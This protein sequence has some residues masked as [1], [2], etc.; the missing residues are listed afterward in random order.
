MRKRYGCLAVAALAGAAFGL[1]WYVWSQPD[2]VHE[3]F[4]AIEHGW[5]QAEVVGVMGEPILV[6]GDV[7]Y[8]KGPT[9]FATVQFSDVTGCV[10]TTQW[11]PREP[12]TV[13]ARFMRWLSVKLQV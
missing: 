10:T 1:C 6:I 8:W 5:T 11:L 13:F 12:E 3:Q 4:K 2:S 9:G 7:F